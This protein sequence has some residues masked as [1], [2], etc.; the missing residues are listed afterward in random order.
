MTKHAVMALGHGLRQV[1]WEYGLRTTILCP[2]FVD[3]D[4]ARGITDFPSEEMT[5]PAD[6][7]RLVELAL[8]LPNSAALSEVTVNC[9]LDERF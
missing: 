2:G 3:T 6:V 4:M 1:G 5:R 9:Q 7:A 8:N